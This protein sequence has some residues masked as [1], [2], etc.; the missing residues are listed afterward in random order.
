MSTKDSK[1][2]QPCTLHS[3]ISRFSSCAN[4]R[5]LTH[6]V[7]GGFSCYLRKEYIYVDNEVYDRRLDAFVKQKPLNNCKVRTV[8]AMVQNG[9]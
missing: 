7:D 2:E 6:N 4:C 8:K 5:A 1:T 3:V 9:L